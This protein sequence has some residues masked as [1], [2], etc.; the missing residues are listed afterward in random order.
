MSCPYCHASVIVPDELRRVS[1]AAAWPVLVI[2]SFTANEHNW[3]VGDLPSKHFA[4]LNQSIIDGRYQWEAQASLVS[5]LTTAWLIGYSLSDFHLLV[6]CKHIRGSR[7]GSSWGVVFRVQDNQNCYWFRLTDAQSFAVS[8]I[9]EGH[10]L[11]L[12]DWTK[13]EAIKP[14]GVNQ[15][16]VIGY[17]MHFTFLINGRM[18]GE[19]E[20]EHF[21]QGLVG[22]GIEVYTPD[23]E[24]R[25]DFLD[26]LVRAPFSK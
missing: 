22:L 23:E 4:T 15:I 7:A 6:N 21:G 2:D 10:W 1:G 11:Q 25:F 9:H 13:T 5:S 17:G 18:V 19:V 26:M 12:V 24:L 16:E 14:K 8:V 20:D 3:L